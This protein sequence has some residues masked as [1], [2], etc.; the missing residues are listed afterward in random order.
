MHSPLSQFFIHSYTN[1]NYLLNMSPNK[2]KPLLKTLLTAHLACSCGPTRP[3]H[4][5]VYQPQPRPKPKPEPEPKPKST[6]S[7]S[8]NGDTPTTL[9]SPAKAHV[10]G[11]SW[12][13]SS[14]D[15][16]SFKGSVAVVKESRDPY[17]DFRQSMLQMIFEDKILSTDDLHNLLRCFLRL[18]SPAHHHFILRAFFEVCDSVFVSSSTPSDDA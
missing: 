9:L 10:P 4:P 6:S 5:I 13:I 7:S 18:N 11:P 15:V 17:E 8:N 2:R 14:G 16:I 1:L 3:N 12:E